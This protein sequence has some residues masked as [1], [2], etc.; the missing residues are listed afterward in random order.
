MRKVIVVILAIAAMAACTSI[1]CPVNN[2]VVT[3]YT[4][5]KADGTADTLNTD[6][7]W[8]I[9]QRTVVADTMVLNSQYDIC[10][11]FQLPIS[12]TQPEDILFL[13]LGD[14]TKTRYVDTI[15]IKKENYP[16]FE[17]VDCS[18]SYFHKITAVSTTH[19]VIDS[20]VIHNADVNYDDKQEHFYIYFKKT[21]R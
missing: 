13:V 12:Y 14:T 21:G 9:A 4:L 1:D 19:N 11:G 2:K 8:V 5:K 18:A 7:I 17:S 6:T 16:H 10:T 3:N 20:I 15:R